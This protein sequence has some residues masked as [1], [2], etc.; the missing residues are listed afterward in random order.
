MKIREIFE[1]KQDFWGKL[2]GSDYIIREIKPNE[3]EVTKWTRGDTPTEI[4]RCYDRGK[5][6]WTCDCPARGKCKHIKMVVDWIKKGKPP[7]YD[8][9]DI[10]KYVKKY[11]GKQ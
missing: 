6:K 10:D 11:L 8:I 5:G 7:A 2:E 9:S 3:Y 1:G 4:Y